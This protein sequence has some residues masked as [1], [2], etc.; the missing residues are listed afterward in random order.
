MNYSDKFQNSINKLKFEGRYRVFN[1]TKRKVGFH[2]LAIWNNNSITSDIIVWCS[3]D[4]LGMSQNKYVT[5]SMINSVKEM[6]TGSGGTRNISGNSSAIVELERELASLHQKEKAIVFSSGYVANEAAISTLL[7]ILDD[8]IVFSDEKNHASIISGIKKSDAH[9]E[10]FKHNDLNELEKLIKKYPYNRAKVIIFE[11]VYSMDGDIGNIEGIVKIAKKYN[12]MTYVDEVHAVGMYG[13]TGA[14][15]SEQL[16]ISNSIDIIQGTLGK[17]YG[18][19]GGYITSTDLICDVIRSYASGYIFT[20]ALPPALAKTAAQSIKYLKNSDVERSLQ[21]KN[22]MLL[23]KQLSDNNINFLDSKSHIIPVMVNDPI[24]CKEISNI[25]LNEFGHYIQPINYPTVPAGSERLRITP[26]PL[27]T[28]KMITELT[29]ALK[30]AFRKT[31][32]INFK[33]PAK[34]LNR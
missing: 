28:E 16:D 31:E 27:H 13:K 26:G 19:M 11:S 10:I 24:R 32:H 33:K 15:I 20:T 18:T 5:N 1:E 22:V 8:A 12:A 17:A 9:K 25:L 30:K 4:Y 3:N 21:Q 23:K 6:G 7:Q 2:P 29:F 34:K 14:G